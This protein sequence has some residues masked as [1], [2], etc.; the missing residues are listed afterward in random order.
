MPKIRRK[1]IKLKEEEKNVEQ[2]V[3]VMN[4]ISPTQCISVTIDHSCV[5]CMDWI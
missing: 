1:K 2:V 4:L 5:Y 3:F